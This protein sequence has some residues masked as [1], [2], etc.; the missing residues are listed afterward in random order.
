MSH[1]SFSDPTGHAS[2]EKR[3]VLSSASFFRLEFS[4]LEE[5]ILVLSV[6]LQRNNN[7]NNNNKKRK[8][9]FEFVWQYSH[10]PGVEI[11]N[12]NRVQ[13]MNTFI[14]VLSLG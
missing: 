1:G 14:F 8:F 12:S 9:P 13:V 6:V 2:M 11:Y 7:S 10:V 4:S 3:A 5:D